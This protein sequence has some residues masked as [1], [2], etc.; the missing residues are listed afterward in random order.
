MKILL[1]GSGAREHALYDAILKSPLV[2]KE[3]IYFAQ[4]GAFAGGNIIDFILDEANADKY[5]FCSADPVSKVTSPMSLYWNKYAPM[6][7]HLL[8]ITI[9]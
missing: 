2:K 8:G 4:T 3:D 1:F 9:L 7:L 6:D 5:M